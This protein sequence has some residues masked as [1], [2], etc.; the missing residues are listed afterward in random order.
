MMEGVWWCGGD[1]VVVVTVAVT[2]SCCGYC[3]RDFCYYQVGDA[4]G[5]QVRRGGF[6]KGY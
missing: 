1:V 6:H 5:G 3:S 4:M 2:V